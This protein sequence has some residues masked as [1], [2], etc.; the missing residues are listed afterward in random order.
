MLLISLLYRCIAL[1]HL[2]VL[3]MDFSNSPYSFGFP[4]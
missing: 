2:F 4:L 3:E 1:L